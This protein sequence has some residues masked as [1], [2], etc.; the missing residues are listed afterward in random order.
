[1]LCPESA[2]S[3]KQ[4]LQ[5]KV[6]LLVAVVVV[7]VAQVKLPLKE[8]HPSNGSIMK[9][10][11]ERM[12]LFVEKDAV[13]LAVVMRSLASVK[14]LLGWLFLRS[15]PLRPEPNPKNKVALQTAAV[16][17]ALVAM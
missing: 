12:S 14:P 2:H 5:R 7:V 15:S 16:A 9:G 8:S 10:M 17:A 13:A 6:A 1:M 11:K 4:F 3:K